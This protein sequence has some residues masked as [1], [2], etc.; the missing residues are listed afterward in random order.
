MSREENQGG[1]GMNYYTYKQG[2]WFMKNGKEDDKDFK[3]VT[4][5]DKDKKSYQDSGVYVSAIGG[6]VSGIDINDI[7]HE[8]RKFSVLE[9][10]LDEEDKLSMSF[11]SEASRKVLQQFGNLDFTQRVILTAWEKD[12]WS[13]LNIKQ[14][15]EHVENEFMTWDAENFK[16]EYKGGYP[17]R[18]A[19]DASERAKSD[20]AL[21]E[22]DFLRTQAIK[23]KAL[24]P[25][26]VATPSIDAVNAENQLEAS[27]PMDEDI[28]PEDIPF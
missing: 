5:V 26:F 28:N 22:K 7:E 10:T 2:H 16:M 20:F 27:T 3:E 6:I 18:P 15:G 13:K 12:G 14:A 4:L 21:D 17:V 11:P 8:G 9:V 23:I 1:G 19:S 25:E 24:V